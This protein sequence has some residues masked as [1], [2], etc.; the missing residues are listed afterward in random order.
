MAMEPDEVVHGSLWI[1]DTEAFDRHKYCTVLI[2]VGGARGQDEQ[3][4]SQGTTVAQPKGSSI[5]DN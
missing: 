1:V 4:R 3:S 5:Q 2:D